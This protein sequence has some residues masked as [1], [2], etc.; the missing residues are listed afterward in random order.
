MNYFFYLDWF[1]VSKLSSLL[2]CYFR[3]KKTNVTQLKVFK[4]PEILRDSLRWLLTN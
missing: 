2:D 4:G 3:I 1:L